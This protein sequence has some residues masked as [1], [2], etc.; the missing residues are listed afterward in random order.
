VGLLGM[1]NRVSAL[2]LGAGFG[3]RA[4]DDHED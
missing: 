1:S 2:S 4:T 3:I